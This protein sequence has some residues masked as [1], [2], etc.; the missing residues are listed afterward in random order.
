MHL[1]RDDDTYPK[2]ISHLGLPGLLLIVF[3]HQSAA[4]A[5]LSWL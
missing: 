2:R 5:V 4:V 1:L 3:V